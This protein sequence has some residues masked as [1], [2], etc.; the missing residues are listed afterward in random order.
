MVGDGGADR[1]RVVAAEFR[2]GGAQL[3]QQR[4]ARQAVDIESGGQL[5]IANG[6]A[7]LLV[8]RAVDRAGREAQ[9][10]QQRF[11]LGQL[12]GGQRRIAAAEIVPEA[13]RGQDGEADDAAAAQEAR[14]GGSGIGGRTR[15]GPERHIVHIG[16]ERIHARKIAGVRRARQD[17]IS[18]RPI[19]EPSFVDRLSP[20]GMV[21]SMARRRN[22]RRSFTMGGTRCSIFRDAG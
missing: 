11:R 7:A 17:R 1:A 2:L 20:C 18:I 19:A 12:G 10:V 9:L 22:S 3:V 6:A 14:P 13:D 8:D 16:A 21:P 15:S 4:D 5:E